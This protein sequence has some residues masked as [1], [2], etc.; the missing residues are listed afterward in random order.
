MQNMCH[1]AQGWKSLLFMEANVVFSYVAQVLWLNSCDVI[2]LS[3]EFILQSQSGDVV[4][5][6]TYCAAI[7]HHLTL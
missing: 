1:Y 3:E 6:S 4:L 5:A 2:C 7:I